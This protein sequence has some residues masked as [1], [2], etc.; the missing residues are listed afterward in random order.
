MEI[1]SRASNIEWM[2]ILTAIGIYVEDDRSRP[3]KECIIDLLY[4]QSH[5]SIMEYKNAGNQEMSEYGSG[6]GE[7]NS[8]S[9][10]RK[11][12]NPA[13]KWDRNRVPSTK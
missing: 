11:N 9:D 8:P 13:S 3:P 4:R 10:R 7:E 12:M 5:M 1:W 2:D 6:G